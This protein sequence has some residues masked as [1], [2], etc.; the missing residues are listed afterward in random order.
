MG[1]RELG[2]GSV[3]PGSLSKWSW[4]GEATGQTC[5]CW[6]GNTPGLHPSCNVLGFVMGPLLFWN[7]HA[8]RDP[9]YKP[10]LR[11]LTNSTDSAHSVFLFQAALLFFFLWRCR[12]Q[13]FGDLRFVRIFGSGPPD[14]PHHRVI[15]ELRRWVLWQPVMLVARANM[16]VSENRGPE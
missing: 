8:F 12:D 1:K 2:I 7:T 16:G 9:A 3:C 14:F 4:T 6:R 11:V 13:N 10:Q 5:S 15:S